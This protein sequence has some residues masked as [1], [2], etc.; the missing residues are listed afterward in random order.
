MW[1]RSMAEKK[2]CGFA[3]PAMS[4]TLVSS[5]A[6]LMIHCALSKDWVQARYRSSSHKIGSAGIAGKKDSFHNQ[7]IS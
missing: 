3:L 7:E 1:S 2:S 5:F 6:S 4:V